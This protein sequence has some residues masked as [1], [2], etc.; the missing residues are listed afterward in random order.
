MRSCLPICAVLALV[1]ACAT[2]TDEDGG[3]DAGVEAGG[4][5]GPAFYT[6]YCAPGGVC[7]DFLQFPTC[8][9]RQW[10]CAAGSVPEPYC[11]C[12]EGADGGYCRD[13]G[14][15]ACPEPYPVTACF[16]PTCTV[17]H[18]PPPTCEGTTWT[19]PAGFSLE[20]APGC[21]YW[22]APRDAGTVVVGGAD[23]G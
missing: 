14:P 8:D 10:A 4:D 17:E 18:G 3:V 19:C 23:S 15:I 11:R 7:S 1:A 2:A 9:G 16:P 20:P 6:V 5:C 21:L 12:F 13:A 22:A